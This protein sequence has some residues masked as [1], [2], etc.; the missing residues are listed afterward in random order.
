MNMPGMDGKACFTAMRKINPKARAIFAT[1]FAVGDTATWI[2]MPG[3]N[4]F[5]QKPFALEGLIKTI[6]RV[7]QEDA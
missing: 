3:I 5:I 7:L 1:G 4:G 2:R 6:S